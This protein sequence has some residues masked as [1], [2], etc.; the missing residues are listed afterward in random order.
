MGD[1][2]PVAPWMALARLDLEQGVREVPGDK[3]NPA[4]MQCFA[5]VGVKALHDETAWCAAWLG[6]KLKRAGK[7]FLKS[8][9]ARDY[10]KYGHKL[11]EPVAGCIA[12]TDRG[13]GF[14][15]TFFVLSWTDT[16][17][18]GVGGNQGDQVSVATFDRDKVLGWRWP[19]A[20]ERLPPDVDA[21]DHDN[22][23]QYPLPKPEP[24]PDTP[25]L[26]SE[27]YLKANS[28]IFAGAEKLKSVGKGVAAATF[29]VSGLDSVV[30]SAEPFLASAET[31]QAV[32]SR[33]GSIASFALQHIWVVVVVLGVVVAW[34]GS[35]IALARRQDDE[36]GKTQRV[37]Q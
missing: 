10:L 27:T 13:R 7:P 5:D 31:A 6:S 18:T 11:D 26:D 21:T 3:D 35:K 28:R 4:I 2:I 32:A 30:K 20:T 23:G 15:H 12:V 37:I 36:T 9:W 33:L 24:K 25:K 16:T 1:V 17:V 34:E 14:G 19:E 22:G 8:A 29:A